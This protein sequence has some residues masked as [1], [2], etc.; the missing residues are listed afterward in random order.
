MS[1][2]EN[3]K[4]VITWEDELKAYAQEAAER[5]QADTPVFSFRSGIMSLSNEIIP[6]NEVSVIVLDALYENSYYSGN[7]DPDNV[8]EP[9]CHA[10]NHSNTEMAPGPGGESENCHQ[11]PHNQFKTAKNGKGKACKNGRRLY[12]IP[13]GRIVDGRFT[14]PKEV[15]D[16]E[17]RISIMRLPVTSGKLFSEYTKKLTS[18]VNRPPFGVYTRVKVVPDQHTQFK[19]LFSLL[20]V[21]PSDFGQVIM[22]RVKD[23]LSLQGE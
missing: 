5:E 8:V 13:A 20:D 19:V 14:P 16:L 6:G 3:N 23:A 10:I 18:T 15:S 4:A 22:T 2:E 9:D 21:V 1:K 11:C 7:Y 17:G 12:V